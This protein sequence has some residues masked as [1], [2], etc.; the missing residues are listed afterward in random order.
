MVEHSVPKPSLSL[1][2]ATDEI[3]EVISIVNHEPKGS[4]LDPPAT[5]NNSQQLS[6]IAGESTNAIR[7]PNRGVQSGA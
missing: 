4:V 2:T 5:R 6:V 3:C 1:E 7:G